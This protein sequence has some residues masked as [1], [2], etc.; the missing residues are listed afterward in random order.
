MRRSSAAVSPLRCAFTRA[1]ADH[2][3]KHYDGVLKV[4]GEVGNK[5][6]Y[7]PRSYLALAE[8][9][10]AKR[11]QQAASDLR[12]TGRRTPDDRDAVRKQEPVGEH[13][14]GSGHA[15]TEEV[16]LYGRFIMKGYRTGAFA[17]LLTGW[18]ASGAFAQAGKED[19]EFVKKSPTIGEALP[20]LT[21]YSA[22]GK[23]FKTSSLRGQYT[24]LSFG[25]LT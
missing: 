3:F 10:M 8:E 4:D 11:V 21:V 24:V 22:D 7:D 13:G 19:P 5:K 9:S 23:E 2:M 25:C 14:R 15:E 1:V 12:G 18:M 17:V 6:V 16:T 20:D